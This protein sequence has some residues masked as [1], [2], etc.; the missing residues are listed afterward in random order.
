MQLKLTM[1]LTTSVILID[2]SPMRGWT[3]VETWKQ[4][5]VD[6]S[7]KKFFREEQKVGN[8]MKKKQNKSAQSREV[9][10]VAVTIERWENDSLFV[11]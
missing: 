4:A 11:C 7:F 8:Q 1:D 2:N 5:R 3:G 6:D 10:I 9:I